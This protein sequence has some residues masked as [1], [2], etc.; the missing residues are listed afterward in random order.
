MEN[1]QEEF[2]LSI[3]SNLTKN[4]LMDENDIMASEKK[5]KIS[6]LVLPLLDLLS[7]TSQPRRKFP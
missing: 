4:I 1:L 6:F 2:S 5:D 7:A 3:K